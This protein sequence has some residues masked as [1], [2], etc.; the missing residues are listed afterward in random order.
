MLRDRGISR[1]RCAVLAGVVCAL[2]LAAFAQP[3]RALGASYPAT[4]YALQMTGNAEFQAVSVGKDDDWT[5]T[6]TFPLNGTGISFQRG[7]WIPTGSST[8]TETVY[9]ITSP[10]FSATGAADRNSSLTLTEGGTCS[11]K[12]INALDPEISVTTSGAGS[13]SLLVDWDGSATPFDP[14]DN[15]NSFPARCNDQDDATFEI[16][17]PLTEGLDGG[18]AGFGLPWSK[19]VDT[20]RFTFPDTTGA[21]ADQT[22]TGTSVGQVATTSSQLG[23][24]NCANGGGVTCTQSYPQMAEQL[25]LTKVCSGTVTPGLAP[26]D[27]GSGEPAGTGHKYLMNGTCSPTTPPSGTKITSHKV[28]GRTATFAFSAKHATGYECSLVKAGHA[29]RFSSC[30][31]PKHYK[32][33][34]AGKY[35]FAVRGVNAKGVDKHPATTKFTIT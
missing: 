30:A 20:I 21:S 22:L 25:K 33:L 35:T 5:S 31:S 10:D 17:T 24:L 29:S 19:Y 32:A 16:V 4:E 18:F 27:Y 11:D 8:S 28:S 7:I 12:I 2:M 14:A 15:G 23:G 3:G 26:K 1:R 34:K 6:A 13:S 9:P